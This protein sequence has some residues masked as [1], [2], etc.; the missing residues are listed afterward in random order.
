MMASPLGDNGEGMQSKNRRR[1]GVA[2]LSR[3]LCV[4]PVISK[5][6]KVMERALRTSRRAAF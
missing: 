3:M 2:I 5:Q 1:A 4:I 6:L